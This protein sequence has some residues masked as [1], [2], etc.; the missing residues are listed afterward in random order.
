MRNAETN[1]LPFKKPA[2][3]YLNPMKHLLY[4]HPAWLHGCSKNLHGCTC[5][6]VIRIYPSLKFSIKMC[7]CRA[8]CMHSS[9][10][11]V[12]GSWVFCA[13][14]GV[15]V[16]EYLQASVWAVAPHL[17]FK[18]CGCVL[19][20]L[21]PVARKPSR[22]PELWASGECLEER[23]CRNIWIALRPSCSVLRHL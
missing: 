2:H 10:E 4:G 18:W 8:T 1:S 12:F 19:P 7:A 6:V 17:L 11:F 3:K 21:P 9:T 14:F 20:Q 22:V 16:S 5:T 15:P 13:R 23:E